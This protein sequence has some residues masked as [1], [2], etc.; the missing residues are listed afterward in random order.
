MKALTVSVSEKRELK[1]F[2][3][4][5]IPG[6][7]V[8]KV[9]WEPILNEAGYSHSGLINDAVQASSGTKPIDFRHNT[10]RVF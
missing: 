9:I 5:S 1:K 7:F 8:P 4:G 3:P 2:L 10:A 6:I